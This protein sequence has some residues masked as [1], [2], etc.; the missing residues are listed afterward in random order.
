M[1][2]FADQLSPSRLLA[3]FLYPATS[4]VLNART[5][6]LA[7]ATTLPLLIHS[8][9]SDFTSHTSRS[10]LLKLFYYTQA[11]NFTTHGRRGFTPTLGGGLSMGIFWY[12]SALALR[13]F[14]QWGGALSV[15]VGM[16]IW[17]F[18]HTLW[19]GGTGSTAWL[20][21]GI[22]LA[23][24]SSNFLGNLLDRQ[25]YNVFGWMFLPVGIWATLNGHPA[26]ASGAWIL[27]ASCSI[28]S[29]VAASLFAATVSLT[30]LDPVPLLAV[31]PC[32]AVP[33]VGIIASHGLALSKFYQVGT[34]LLS[35]IGGTRKVAYKRRIS[36]VVPSVSCAA[37]GIFPLYLLLRN[38]IWAPTFDPKW[39]VACAMPVAWLFLNQSKIFR[40]A[41]PQSILFFFLSVS[42]ATIIVHPDLLT[43]FFFWL[44]N[45][46]PV[47]HQLLFHAEGNNPRSGGFGVPVCEPIDVKPAID[48]M[49]EFLRPIPK[50]DRVLVAYN[51]PG[52]DYNQI[53]ADLFPISELVQHT[54]HRLSL[55]AVPDIYFLIY[56][57]RD[58][59]PWGY[60]SQ[61]IKD[62]CVAIGARYA[63]APPGI[64]DVTGVSLVGCLALTDLGLSL[65]EMI[66]T[67]PYRSG[68]CLYRVAPAPP[69]GH[70]SA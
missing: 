7:F 49:A 23:A 60:E 16:M 65:T 1:N 66:A 24:I 55:A 58:R 30:T 18:S 2:Y 62:H 26:V 5:L 31:M 36:L 14:R 43:L 59:H 35:I 34:A 57:P 63:I 8:R 29:A 41:D 40:I 3:A 20:M 50:G 47:V 45:S 19:L 32:W 68:L 69:Q 56:S 15:F 12:Q 52:S 17:A 10:A 21:A 13:L 25:N 61:V 70:I 67:G 38:L 44:A 46:N 28:T 48:V 4:L 9:R 33:L 39:V 22:F 51:D 37:I 54:A 42:T 11:D 64:T 27:A 6:L 53:F